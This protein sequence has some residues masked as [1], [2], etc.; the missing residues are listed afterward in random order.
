M[1]SEELLRQLLNAVRDGVA[2]GVV[3]LL[4]HNAEIVD[5]IERTMKEAMQKAAE[6][7]IKA[8]LGDK[9]E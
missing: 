3:D 9:N 8:Y 1:N 4:A 6:Q 2:E 7:M 5:M